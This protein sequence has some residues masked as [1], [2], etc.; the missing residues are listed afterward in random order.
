LNNSQLGESDFINGCKLADSILL[1]LRGCVDDFL[2]PI[3]NTALAHIDSAK[4]SHFRLACLEVL[5][6]SVLYN[7]SAALHFME[8]YSSGMARVFFDKWFAAI[9]TDSGLP[10]VY[11]K[12]LTIITLC[13]LMELDPAGIPETLREGWP[14]IVAGALKVFKDLPKAVAARKA[15]EEAFEDES[16]DEGSDD[17]QYLNLNDEE[18]DVW[19]EES[20]YMELLAKEGARLR[21]RNE[22]RDAGEA[23]SETSSESEEIEEELGFFSPLDNINPY[24]NFK[25]ALTTFQMK[26]GSSYQVATTSLNMDQQTFLMELMRQAEAQP[27]A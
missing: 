24:V 9:N 7:P 21:E 26:N 19:D 13:A 20:A 17:G 4:T 11:D 8:S 12:K 1:N 6:N 23:A 15:L 10:R 5:I 3:I 22:K 14:G 2:Q 27:T 18:E 25:Q 16:D